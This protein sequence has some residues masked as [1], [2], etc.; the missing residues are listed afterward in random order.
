MKLPKLPSAERKMPRGPELPKL[1]D[2]V[3]QVQ[4]PFGRNQGWWGAYAPR[5]SPMSNRRKPKGGT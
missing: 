2:P 3:Q 5:I 1:P 4:G